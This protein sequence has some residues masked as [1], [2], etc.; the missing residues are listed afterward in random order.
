[1][2]PSFWPLTFFCQISQDIHISG[3][4]ARGGILPKQGGARKSKLMSHLGVGPGVVVAQLFKLWSLRQA[5]LCV[6]QLP[7]C[8]DMDT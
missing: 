8:V 5:E 3:G 6:E 7:G 4:G 2:C 1:M